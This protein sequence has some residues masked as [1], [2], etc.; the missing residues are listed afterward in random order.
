MAD[1]ED[2]IERPITGEGIGRPTAPPTVGSCG[3]RLL[4]APGQPAQATINLIGFGFTLGRLSTAQA[5]GSCSLLGD[6]HFPNVHESRL[7]QFALLWF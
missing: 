4:F 6:V 5:T 1:S 7:P 2:R 3:D